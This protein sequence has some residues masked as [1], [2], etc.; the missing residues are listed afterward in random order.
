MA[1]VTAA[2]ARTGGGLEGDIHTGA[3][4]GITLISARQWREVTRELAAELPWHTRRA[5]VLID[6]GGLQHLIG[7]TIRIGE[8]EID[9]KDE[10]RPCGLMD[11]LH[12]GLRAALKPD[13]R[14]GVNGQITRGGTLRVGDVVSIMG[15]TANSA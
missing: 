7:Q 15:A 5:N 11:E 6:A 4:R 9:I 12:Q 1:E 13:C 8:V 2:N 10:T 3:D 14:G